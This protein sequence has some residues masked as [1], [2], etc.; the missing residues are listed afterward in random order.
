MDILEISDLVHV[1]DK[2][3]WASC[4]IGFKKLYKDCKIMC[5]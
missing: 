5:Q 3:D 1:V 2:R 4:E